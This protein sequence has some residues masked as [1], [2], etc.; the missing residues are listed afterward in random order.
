MPH[1]LEELRIQIADAVRQAVA[2][3]RSDHAE[4]SGF[5]LCTDDDV[6]TLY[7]VA[8]TRDWVRKNEGDYPEIGFIYVEWTHSA[9]A[10]P[11]DAISRQFAA[12]ADADYASEE[13]WAAARDQRFKLLVSALRD[14]REGDAFA[15]ETL[16]CAGSTDPS[17]HLEALAMS[18]VEAVNT[19]DV[20]N[21]FASALGYE[22]HR[23]RA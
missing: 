13:A 3:L 23:T 19:A 14:C 4:L 20:A 22:K 6:R 18:G 5:A 2:E 8:C 11:F 16:L 15:P 7:H 9:D 12:L 1:P 17:E 21:Q 10:A